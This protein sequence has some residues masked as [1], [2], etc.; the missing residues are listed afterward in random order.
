[1]RPG[2]RTDQPQF[3]NGAVAAAAAAAEESVWVLGS[4]PTQQQH[5]LA[6]APHQAAPDIARRPARRVSHR[7]TGTWHHLRRHVARPAWLRIRRSQVKGR[8]ARTTKVPASCPL[9]AISRSDTRCRRGVENG[10]RFWP[11]F[12]NVWHEITSVEISCRYGCELQKDTLAAMS[13]SWKSFCV[14][15]ISKKRSAFRSN[16]CSLS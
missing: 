8:T 13:A 3:T 9:R 11:L 7:R 2:G 10:L 6:F 1:M 12:T 5:Q 4:P 16:T 15:K 14:Q